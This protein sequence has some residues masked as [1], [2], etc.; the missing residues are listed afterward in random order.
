ML[1]V[2][3]SA[4]RRTFSVKQRPA[5]FAEAGVAAPFTTPAIAQARLRLDARGRME[6]VARNP[7]G[8]D[9]VYVLPLKAA[10]EM[11]RLSIH[12]RTLT[13]RLE[14]VQPISPLTIRRIGLEL[15][16]EGLA[17]LD[18]RDAALRA[19]DDDEQHAL[20]TLLL[21]LEQLLKEA[22]QPRID[23]K[24]IDTGDRQARERLKPYF[25]RLEPSTGMV[26]TDLVSAVDSLSAL[27]APVGLEG[28]PF[29][30]LAAATLA[31][32]RK[33]RTSV[34]DWARDEGPELAAVAGLVVECAALSVRCAE[35]SLAKAGEL[36]RTVGRL[37]A[38][39]AAAPESVGEVLTRPIW[40]LH[41]WR[42]LI[43]LWSSVADRSRDVQRDTMVELG[44]LVPLVPLVADD[45]LNKD[46]EK[47]RPQYELRRHVRLM[48]D[49]RSGLTIER[50]AM[51]E[52]VQAASL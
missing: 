41:G 48:E 52:R 34:A 1:E 40:L 3:L 16:R 19:I 30:S 28:A 37:L 45:W 42:H 24:A 26:G 22:G 21:L 20:L 14:A 11:F 51:I 38:A 32:L 44:E 5:T 4:R 49:W 9:G 35:Q 12:D 7:T 46:G 2:R 13:E 10:S 43:A 6:I 23:W 25:R 50:Q 18:A 36:V 39:H 33:L 29:E 31:D 27:L 15:A 47:Q 8:G 17:G